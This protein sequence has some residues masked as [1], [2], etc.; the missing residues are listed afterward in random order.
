[1]LKPGVSIKQFIARLKHGAKKGKN[2]GIKILHCGFNL[3]NK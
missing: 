2:N 1:M 3:M